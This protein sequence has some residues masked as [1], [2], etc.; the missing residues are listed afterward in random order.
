[1]S[2]LKIKTLTVC[3]FLVFYNCKGQES[4][5]TEH[6]Q[7]QNVGGPCEGC[8]AIFEYGSKKLKSK[9][10]LPGFEKN[11]QK[12]TITGTI[13]EKD[14]KTPAE[15]II[16]YIYH[17]ND[18]GIYET[19]GNETGWAKRHGF[20]RGWIKT[21]KDGKYTFYT[22][23]P[24]AYPNRD[25]PVHIHITVKEP[26]TNP[27]YLD[28]YLFDDDPLLTPNKRKALKNRGG[29]G[30]VAPKL[31]N[32]MLTMKRDIILGKNIPDYE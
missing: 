21:N 22:F 16:A 7:E 14:G 30:I 25:E 2:H 32:G 3:I 18:Q 20:I 26:N 9:D 27:Y 5:K 13:F 24:A 12:L 28:D 8:E 17:T 1:M 11:A 15:N 19:K 6:G 10:T 4:K 31:E 23:R 29:S